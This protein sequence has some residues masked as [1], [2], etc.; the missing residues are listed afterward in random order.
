M[1]R[2]NLRKSVWYIYLRWNVNILAIILNIIED[3]CKERKYA[4]WNAV[5]VIRGV[6]QDWFA[7]V[8]YMRLLH[9]HKVSFVQERYDLTK[10]N[11]LNL[12]WQNVIVY[13][14][15]ILNHIFCSTLSLLF[16]CFLLF[17]FF[18]VVLSFIL[19]LNSCVLSFVSTLKI[20]YE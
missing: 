14:N 9:F 8:Y 1:N 17:L 15:I 7:L 3:H 11:L 2:S 20:L 4:K 5:D 16:F 19:A 18:F 10:C 6:I 13:Y 12:W